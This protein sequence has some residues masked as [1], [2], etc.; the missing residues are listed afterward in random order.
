[1]ASC[2][3][4]ISTDV[5]TGWFCKGGTHGASLYFFVVVLMG[6]IVSMRYAGHEM[7]NLGSR[8]LDGI[9]YNLTLV[10][11]SYWIKILALLDEDG[12]QP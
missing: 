2:S 11:W 9:F 4:I 10:S 6:L 1:M 7:L 8:L 12:Q 5:K 3:L